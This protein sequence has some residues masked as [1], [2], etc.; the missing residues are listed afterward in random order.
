MDKAIEL[1][2]SDYD[3]Y[4]GM[5]DVLLQQRRFEEIA[6]YWKKYIALKPNDSRAYFE[7]AG[8]YYHMKRFDLA[9]KDARKAVKLGHPNAEES[10]L[11]YEADL[12][13]GRA[14]R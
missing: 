14:K 2:H 1:N 11:R 9:V 4:K 12:I 7:R 3:S 13:G 6:A 5:D 10:L 8:T